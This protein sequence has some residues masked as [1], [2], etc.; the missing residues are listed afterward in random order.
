MTQDPHTLPEESS[1]VETIRT[2]RPLRNIASVVA[3]AI[4]G[5]TGYGIALWILW[6]PVI[7]KAS[8]GAS[9]SRC[10]KNYFAADQFSVMSIARNVQ[11]GLPLYTEP[12]S[13]TGD[14][15]YPSGYYWLLGKT[16]HGTGTTVVWSWNVI[17]FFV[18]CALLVMAFLVVR[19]LAPGTRAWL[20]AP[21][22][23]LV[24]TLY[25]WQSGSWFYRSGSAVVWPPASSLYSPGAENP[26]LVL[27]G[28]SLMLIT[29]AFGLRRPRAVIAA[30]SSGALL[31]LT[32]HL[33]ANIAVFAIVVTI[34][35]FVVDYLLSIATR[36]RQL[37][38]AGVA[39]L[40]V[41]AFLTAPES[42]FAL[43]FGAALIVLLAVLAADGEWRRRRGVAA[44]LWAATAA[45]ASLPLALRLASQILSGEGYYYQRQDSVSA[46]A[47]DS[48]IVPVILLLLPIWVL[49]FVALRRLKSKR[50]PNRDFWLPML[51]GLGAATLLLAFGGFWGAR[52]LEWNRFLIYG[53]FFLTLWSIPAIWLMLRGGLQRQDQVVGGF[54]VAILL[55]TLPTTYVFARDQRSGVAC[56][57][58]Q[59]VAAYKKIGQEDA[60][61]HLLLVDRCIFPGIFKVYSGTRVAAF[62]LGIAPPRDFPATQAALTEIQA[63]RLP[64]DA[65]LS[66]VGATGFVTHTRCDGVS[67][68]ELVGR[69]GPPMIR[70]PVSH[71]ESL[72]HPD[73]ITYEV[74]DLSRK[75]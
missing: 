11:D 53:S 31:G 10:L 71:P 3:T 21:T 51:S 33:H 5:T 57:P 28:L 74:Y 15:V 40:V 1:P 35:A 23:F 48:P 62:N 70:V 13:A 58:E 25:W 14:S 44:G 19:R 50:D 36:R 69:F 49:A 32:L 30:S 17:G 61:R 6:G 73:G 18:S 8:S 20:L 63:G 66:A 26:A 46:A 67:R 24:G 64:D 38:V 52:G 37:I 7:S 54:T 56:Y 2:R 75:S 4:A 68:K 27:A 59:E 9:L 22:P 72:G 65:V 12:Y 34:L 45:I 16:A 41:I 60:R 55:A 29:W 42:G 47:V 39:G 43:R